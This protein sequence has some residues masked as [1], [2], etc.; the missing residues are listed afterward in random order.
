MRLHFKTNWRERQQTERELLLLLWKQNE[1]ETGLQRAIANMTRQHLFLLG[2]QVQPLD[3]IF[4]FI[5]GTNISSAAVFKREKETV[6]CWDLELPWWWPCLC[7]FKMYRNPTPSPT[8]KKTVSACL[9][10]L[11]L[12]LLSLQLSKPKLKQSKKKCIHVSWRGDWKERERKL[13]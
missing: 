4:V 6:T 11:T 13:Q 9:K 8:E 5:K 1:M 7:H 3:T 2:L 12:P 10:N